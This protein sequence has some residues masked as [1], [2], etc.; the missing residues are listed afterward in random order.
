MVAPRACYRPQKK[1]GQNTANQTRDRTWAVSQI[2]FEE[3]DVGVKLRCRE[4]A[5]AI[6]CHR[7]T[8]TASLIAAD[9]HIHPPTFVLTSMLQKTLL[10]LFVIKTLLLGYVRNNTDFDQLDKIDKNFR[11]FL[12][13]M[14]NGHTRVSQEIHQSASARRLQAVRLLRAGLEL[15]RVDRGTG[16]IS[17]RDGPV[18]AEGHYRK[19]FFG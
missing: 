12:R 5:S 15:R 2:C 16:D 1:R 13:P 3:I 19:D 7:M 11:N 14:R 9:C 4:Q 18:V 17:R 10:H 6:A 8:E